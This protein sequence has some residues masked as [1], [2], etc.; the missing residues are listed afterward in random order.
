[1]ELS[2][3]VDI[4]KKLDSCKCINSKICFINDVANKHLQ[5]DLPNN[6]KTNDKCLHKYGNE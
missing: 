6:A 5:H 1:M 2:D 3:R 4:M